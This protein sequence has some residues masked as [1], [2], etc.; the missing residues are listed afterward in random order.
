MTLENIKL[1]LLLI[2]L[3]TFFSCKG[4]IKTESLTTQNKVS[5]MMKLDKKIWSIYQDQKNNYWFGSNG[6]G[7]FHYDGKNL[8]KYTKQDGLVDNTIRGIQED[9]L[10]NIY[11]QTP[12]GI[13]KY[14][15]K[16][17]TT[18][19]PIV[20]PLNQW[21]LEPNDLW[22]N[23]NGNANHIYR[24][25]GKYLFELTLPKQGLKEAFGIE[26]EERFSPYTVYG[27]DK[28]K[29]GNLWIGMV[30]AGAFRY[31]GKSFLWF[32]EKEL[33]T[34]PDGRVPGVRSM[35]E[36]KDGYFWLSNFVSKYKII[37]QDGTIE[38]EKLKGV[39]LSKGYFKS[40]LPYFNSGLSDNNGDL[41]MTTYT[42]GVWKYD[43]KELFNFSVKDGDTEALLI[44]IYQDHQG[45]LWVGTDN[46]GVFKFDGKT[47][48]K[49]EPAAQ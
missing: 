37:D 10:G 5:S 26:E 11:I 21:S 22:F 18:L 33:S 23:C 27:I 7:V 19:E 29:A 24:Y 47:F 38:Y 32:P 30:V 16:G 46:V 44:C 45:V 43:G 15:G 31:D 42:G 48:V 35:L 12:E 41:W 13:S 3:T 28:D 4:Q 40:R 8:K 14:D 36:D 39:D 17:F 20:S 49:F 25:D 34:L 6:N 2:I 1:I 9:H